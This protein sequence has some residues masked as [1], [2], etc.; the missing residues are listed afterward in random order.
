[1]ILKKIKKSKEMKVKYLELLAA[2]GRKK[3][4]IY[5]ELVKEYLKGFY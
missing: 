3:K 4:Y 5:E 1:M 2:K